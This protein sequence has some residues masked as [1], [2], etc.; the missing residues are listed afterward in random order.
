MRRAYYAALFL[1]ATLLS[2]GAQAAE[3][4]TSSDR[5]RAI[6]DAGVD[7]PLVFDVYDEAT[8]PWPRLSVS[9]PEGRATSEADLARALVVRAIRDTRRLVEQAPGLEPE[10]LWKRL[11][12][13]LRLRAVLLADAHY[14]DLLLAD[15]LSRGMTISLCSLLSRP[16]GDIVAQAHAFSV[17]LQQWAVSLETWAAI[18]ERDF[19]LSADSLRAIRS[20]PKEED[21]FWMLWRLLS[22]DDESAF[23]KGV[24]ASGSLDLV[25]SPNLA[26]LLHRYIQTDLLLKTISLAFKYRREAKGS[27]LSDP[28][29]AIAR[30]IP[31]PMP[32]T[33]YTLKKEGVEKQRLALDPRQYALGERFLG[34]QVSSPEVA[35]L[36][37]SVLAGDLRKQ[38]FFDLS[39]LRSRRIE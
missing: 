31:P 1:A 6:L 37:Q 13:G 17:K 25:G 32:T 30:V 2:G 19:G 21:S 14:L 33:R 38:L 20:V 39:D 34:I 16:G 26:L 12:A 27:S 4:P 35:R 29:E 15:A 36:F 5:W 10:R 11:E 28:E 22:H 7:D 8:M 9:S 3:V 23:P 24:E 18:A